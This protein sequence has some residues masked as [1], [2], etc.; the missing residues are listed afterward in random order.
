MHG[1]ALSVLSETATTSPAIQAGDG[2]AGV[3]NVIDILASRGLIESTTGEGLRAACSQAQTAP[4]KVYVGFDPTAESLHLGHLLG[5]IVL[6]WFQRCGHVPV[7]VVGGATGRVGD[8]SGKR[9]ERPVLDED[10][11][12]RNCRG[13]EG[14]ISRLLGG[15]GLCAQPCE[16]AA[17]L[18][19]LIVLNNYDWWKDM[20]VLD[21]LWN[22]G[23]FAR[24][25]TMLA[26]DSVRS[27]LQSEVGMSYTE[28]TYQLIQGYDFVHLFRE[29]GVSVQ[30]G[31]SD[32]WG[33]ITAGT[34]L[35]R[36]ILQQEG[37]HGLT[38]PLLLKSDGT[39]IGK[40]EGGAIWLN[41]SLLSPHKF[42]QYLLA[43]QD[44]DVIKVLKML[45]FL[46]LE[47]I[48]HIQVSMGE[49]DY[50]PK[51]A[52][53]KLAEEVTRFVHGDKGVEEALSASREAA[54]QPHSIAL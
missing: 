35:I 48:E 26:K 54:L 47:E 3:G 31:G 21:F 14:T 33:N 19:T 41:P 40:S 34:D 12:R 32:Q 18:P 11:I 50:V 37:A 36:R 7:A 9:T 51:S 52:Q 20:S 23:R 43:T 38:H 15:N 4:L 49:P 53:S 6:S 17:G 45:T 30:A 1:R 46:S 25:G 27:R 8:P 5:I 39:K 2:Q 13:I 10:T 42:Y 22:V 24:V 29:K 28:F 44:S 16:R